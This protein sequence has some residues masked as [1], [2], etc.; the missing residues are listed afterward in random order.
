MEKIYKPQ[1]CHTKPLIHR[2]KIKMIKVLENNIGGY[3]D[4]LELKRF[5]NYTLKTAIFK[6]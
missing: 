3:L 4:N 5:L 2:S 6:K 1:P